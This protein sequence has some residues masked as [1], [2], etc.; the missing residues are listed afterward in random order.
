M[1]EAFFVRWFSYFQKNGNPPGQN[2]VL[3]VSDRVILSHILLHR[4]T[5]V[6]SKSRLVAIL[7]LLCPRISSLLA[8]VCCFVFDPEFVL[9]VD[10]KFEF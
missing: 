10:L 9:C 6:S 5:E 4:H 7:N 3:K 2:F 8:L 1:V